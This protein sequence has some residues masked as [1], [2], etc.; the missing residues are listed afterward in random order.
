M[1]ADYHLNPP[2]PVVLS[3]KRCQTEKVFNNSVLEI[4]ILFLFTVILSLFGIG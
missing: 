2:Y 1:K 4:R 3:L